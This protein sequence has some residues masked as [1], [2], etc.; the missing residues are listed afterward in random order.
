MEEVVLAYNKLTVGNIENVFREIEGSYKKDRE[1]SSGILI[2]ILAETEIESNLLAVSSI[3]KLIHAVL[4]KNIVKEVV[5][6]VANLSLWCYI[7]NYGLVDDSFINSK[8]SALIESKDFLSVLK[9]LQMCSTLLDA[10][11]LS[12]IE[13]GIEE[14]GS[15]LLRFVKDSIKMIRKGNSPYRNYLQEE[16]N[17]VKSTISII[18]SKYSSTNSEIITTATDTKEIIATKFGMNTSLKKKIFDI[19]TSSQDFVDAQRA[20]YKQV[21]RKVWHIEEVAKIAIDLCI[22][23]N[24]YNPYYLL[25]IVSLHDT[26]STNHRST[27]V[28]YIYCAVDS[29]LESLSKLSIK[30]I[31]NLGV[32][33]CELYS[34]GINTLRRL[35]HMSLVLKKEE[36]LARVVFKNILHF[37]AQ[38]KIKKFRKMKENDTFKEFFK[39]KMIDGSFLKEED[40]SDMNFLYSKMFIQM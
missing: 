15:V 37:Y 3:L 22:A 18:L 19:I 9:V 20:L 27:V 39:I 36:V 26:S 23:E 16:M 35:I 8:V 32:A 31:Y 7:Y 1:E 40:R 29:K 6:K 24:R 4:D 28:K 5:N 2:K 11:T 13:S 25:L 14:D 17:S 30:E 10:S 21:I 33:M 34:S 12:L 38:N